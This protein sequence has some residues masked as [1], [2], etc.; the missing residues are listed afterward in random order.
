M[1]EHMFRLI[2]D[3]DVNA[4]VK[5]MIKKSEI[6][7]VDTD[8]NNTTLDNYNGMVL[9]SIIPNGIIYNPMYISLDTGERSI[10]STIYAITFD[11]L[12]IKE[13]FLVLNLIANVA[14]SMEQKI[15]QLKQQIDNE[16]DY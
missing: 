5:D 7:G 4:A 6:V 9:Q 13:M 15:K 3:I 12:S 11:K 10:C 14:Y 8:Y 16:E 1:T 2:S